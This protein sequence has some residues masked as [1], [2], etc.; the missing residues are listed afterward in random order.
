MT[1][2][3]RRIGLLC[4][5]TVLGGT[6]WANDIETR[7]F[8]V[9]V[10][11]KAAG[12]VHMTIQQQDASTVSLRCDTEIKVSLG[13]LSYRYSFRGVEVWKDRRL[14][15]LESSTDD[16]TKR[17][18]VSANPVADGLNVKVN[19]AE[20]KV[21]PDAWTSSYW[22]LPD[23]KLRSGSLLILDA[24]NGTDLEGKLAYVATEK[25]RI[26]GQEVSLNH[27]RLTGKTTID[28]WYDGT[29]RL[30]RQEWMEQGHKTIMVLVR[31][32]R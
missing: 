2:S 9:L 30:V 11:G 19:G 13:P 25:H 29:E 1:G 27:Y 23:P 17:F 4:L 22:T 16:N 6:A 31:V 20:R 15:R 7:D 3:K 21:K 28:L 12:E 18:T 14:T 5:L 26:A 8:A 32:R 24:D 10:G